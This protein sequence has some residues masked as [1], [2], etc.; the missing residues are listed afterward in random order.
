MH[1]K[2][3]LVTGSSDGIGRQTALELAQMGARV[4]VH[5]RSQAR[6]EQAL[7]G[8]QALAPAASFDLVVGDLASLAEVRTI[9][10]A[11]ISRY[12]RLDVLINNA[13]IKPTTRQVSADGYELTLAVN[14]LAHFL[15]TNL[16]LPLITRTPTARV[17]TVSSVSHTRGSIFFDDLQITQG[18]DSYKAYAQSKL[19]NALFAFELARRVLPTGVTSNA[20][21]PGVVSTKLL[22]EGFGSQG[23][24]SLSAGAATSIYLA[25]SPDVA[26]VTGR[27]F[28]ERSEHESAPISHDVG[29]QAQLWTVSA[30][31][32]GLV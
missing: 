2:T 13:G 1:G 27:Y 20:L 7:A 32:T 6:G 21:H 8:L 16:L 3:V 28:Q 11:V 26:G 30:Q 29:L 31:L 10:D 18:W 14:H 4:I 19:A 5:A 15:L 23:S 25:S 22:V 9:A 17:V 12:E 24:D